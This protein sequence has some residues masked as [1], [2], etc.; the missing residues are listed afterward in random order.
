MKLCFLLFITSLMFFAVV[1]AQRADDYNLVTED[2][3]LEI[4][5]K[6]LV[7]GSLSCSKGVSIVTLEA[8]FQSSGKITDIKIL[9]PSGCKSFDK[10]ALKSTKKI[11]FKPE[12]K[13]G[14]AV[15]VVKKI[16]Y[17]YRVEY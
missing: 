3:P 11:K 7:R 15:T 9:E 6:P 5:Y 2:R 13:N 16:Q 4:L 10:N 8:V 17:S 12:I 1:K 14:E